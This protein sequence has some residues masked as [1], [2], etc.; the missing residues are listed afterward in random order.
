MDDKTIKQILDI[1][2]HFYESYAKEFSVTRQAPWPG[3]FGILGILS[4]K[5]VKILDLG[6]GKGKNKRRSYT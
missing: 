5:K 2:C 4:A 3:W 6:C 1:N